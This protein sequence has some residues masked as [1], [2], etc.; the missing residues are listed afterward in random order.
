MMSK[1][2]IFE[3]MGVFYVMKGR[4]AQGR[5]WLIERAAGELP[6]VT[7]NSCGAPNLV[8]VA[9]PLTPK[10]LLHSQL[11]M[12]PMAGIVWPIRDCE[13]NMSDFIGKSSQI[14]LT[15]S[16]LYKQFGVRFGVRSALLLCL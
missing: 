1:Q 3:R 12:E 9:D 2:R 15:N 4:G 13:T 5:D 7:P 10:P 14:I 11:E 8:S 16:Y 6:P